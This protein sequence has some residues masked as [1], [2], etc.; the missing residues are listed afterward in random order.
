M[1]AWKGETEVIMALLLMFFLGDGI[2][3]GILN[4]QEVKQLTSKVEEVVEDTKRLKTA[5]KTLKQLHKE[6]RRLERSFSKSGRQLTKLFVDHTTSA[7]QMSEVFD[8]LNLEWEM[9][10]QKALG[11]RWDLKLSLTES[12]WGLVFDLAAL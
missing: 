1:V 9:S 6:S 2:T 7:D 5:R 12:E 3:G 10:Q 11:I 8:K 4:S